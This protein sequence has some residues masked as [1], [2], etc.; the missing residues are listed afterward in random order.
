MSRSPVEPSHE[1]A[2]TCFVDKVKK[3][4]EEGCNEQLLEKKENSIHA[5]LVRTQQQQK[6]EGREL[7]QGASNEDVVEKARDQYSVDYC[8]GVKKKK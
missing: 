4:L 2:H 7:G 8:W 3:V 5:K 1:R 6:K